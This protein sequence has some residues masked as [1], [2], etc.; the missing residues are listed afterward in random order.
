MNV[1]IN[2]RAVGRSPGRGTLGSF[3]RLLAVVGAA[4]LMLTAPA[5]AHAQGRMSMGMRG[6]WGG[7]SMVTTR[8][9]TKW[10]EMLKLTPDQKTAVE[11]LHDAYQEQYREESKAIA[12]IAREARRE[13]METQ[14]TS[15]FKEIGNRTAEHTKRMASL[16]SQFLD[17]FKAVLDPKQVEKWPSVERAHRREKSLPGGML[18]GERTDLVSIFD[19]LDIADP[20]PGLTEAI[21]RYETDLDRALTE[22]DEQRRAIEKKSEEMMK[23]FDPSRMDFSK[24]RQMMQDARKTGVR[25]RDVNE[26]HARLIAAALPDDK[27][28]EFDKRVREQTYPMVY[29]EPYTSKAIDAALGFDGLTP[30]QKSSIDALKATYTRELSAADEKWAAAIS[31][32]E[33]DGGGDPFMGFGRFVPGGKDDPS[34]TEEARKARRE[35]DKST[36]EKLKAVLTPEQAEKLPERADENPWMM[37]FG[38]GGDD[39]ADVKPDKKPA[40]GGKK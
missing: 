6:G 22:R 39:A 36:L 12:D 38:G 10:A 32:E 27:R 24:I 14:D 26:R 35:L 16:E 7:N 4:A 2:R 11:A 15:A 3:G 23:D 18:S 37:N 5:P 9:V 40:R 8:E 28:A 34:P 13:F 33:K 21:E 30:E 31:A 25:V 29:R 20:Q 1:W 17:D 19:E